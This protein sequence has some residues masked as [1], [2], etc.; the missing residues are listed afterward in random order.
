MINLE[1]KSQR[2]S[3]V[4]QIKS[5]E[6]VERKDTSHKASEV[7]K[8]RMNPFVVEVLTKRYTD[9]NEIPVVSSINLAKRIVNQEASIYKESP[10][11]IFDGVDQ[12]EMVDTYNEM[13][14]DA[15]MLQV[16]RNYRLE[17]QNH[18]MI[19][20][21][22][23]KLSIRS[24]KGF[25]IDVFN[26]AENPE[27]GDIYVLSGY[28]KKSDGDDINQTIAEYDDNIS[29]EIYI[30]WSK[31][32]H[33]S[34][35]ENGEIL[36][37]DTVNELGIIPIVDIAGAKDFTYW[38][39]EGNALVDFCIFYNS[40]M[41]GHGF[42]VE[43]QA[44]AQAYI[45]SSAELMPQNVQI[46]PT[47]LLKLITD[48]DRD[49]DS[50]FG[51]AQTGA[52]LAGS[53]AYIE[54]LL[55]NFLTAR[56]LDPKTIVGSANSST[57][58]ASGMERLLALIEKFEASKDDLYLFEVIEKQ[59]FEIIKAWSKILPDMK[60]ISDDATVSVNFKRPEMIQTEADKVDLY[61]KKAEL[62][63]ASRIDGVMDLYNMDKEQAIVKI[64]EI[65]A[66]ELSYGIPKADLFKE[67]SSTE[68]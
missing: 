43:M 32:F 13:M 15:K 12:V 24:L 49:A 17:N 42:T 9:V 23:G 6:N 53:Q 20:P 39:D 1:D 37:E 63:L 2:K 4:D 56:G 31:D 3:L 59:L 16:N 64:K 62:G 30:V 47:K 60:P 7:Y 21:K 26:G 58:Y 36:S 14:F 28:D 19:I 18:A 33:F 29:E 68:I 22:N 35:D 61:M 51:F 45:K 27:I 46:G 52:D 55:S 34:M 25:Q 11:R 50:E 66:M 48:P 38:I 65:D 8:D 5:S 40:A 10:E 41:S 54:L 67:E 44:F 57:S